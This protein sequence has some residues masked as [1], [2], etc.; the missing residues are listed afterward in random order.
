MRT[1]F[2]ALLFL[3]L[4]LVSFTSEAGFEAGKH[5][6]E[7]GMGQP[8]S[9]D[10]KIEVREFFWYGCPH[11]YRLEPYLDAW[12]EKRPPD[13]TYVRTPGVAKS[14][15]AHA[16]AYYAFEAL[17]ITDKVHRPFFDA[18]HKGGQKL[19]D[20]SSIK[21]FLA[22]YGVDGESFRK[23]FNSFGVRTQVEKAKQ[24]NFRYGVE[25]VPSVTIGG[26]YKTSASM[27]GSEH[28][29]MQLIDHLIEKTRQQ[30]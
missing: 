11:C 17:G 26:K 28:Q 6:V 19:T 3:T 24:L 9:A 5:Y 15:I 13:V 23:A 30:R 25:S 18:I 12:L 16:K 27:A 10:G 29:L 14:W 20:E 22:N 21:T 2:Y 1:S 7:L 4:S 8:P